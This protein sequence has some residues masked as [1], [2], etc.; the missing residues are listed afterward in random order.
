MFVPCETAR[1]HVK[2]KFRCGSIVS[3]TRLER[4][5]GGYSETIPGVAV[6]VLHIGERQFDLNLHAS[7][8]D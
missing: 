1:P 5:F 4:V 2:M 8:T 7:G 3:F 6:F